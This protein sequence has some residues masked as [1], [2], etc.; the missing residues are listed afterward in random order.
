MLIALKG[1]KYDILG[2]DKIE[3]AIVT[4]GGVD[5]KEVSPKDMQSKIIP[6]LYFIG[7]VLDIDALTGGFNIQLALSTAY[8][9]ARSLNEDK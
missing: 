1:L 6:N 7:E 2:I 3:F 5:V 8:A 9:M 4:S